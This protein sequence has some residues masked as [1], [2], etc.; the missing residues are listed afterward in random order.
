MDRK[1]YDKLSGEQ[2]V[3]LLQN[4]ARMEKLGRNLAQCAAIR[5]FVAEDND[6]F[7][8]SMKNLV[9]YARSTYEEAAI[10]EVARRMAAQKKLDDNVH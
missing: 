8:R 10:Q 2:K 6:R 5:Q 7:N 4:V 1:S 3:Q 9:D